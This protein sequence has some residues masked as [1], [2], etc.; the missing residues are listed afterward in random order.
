MFFVVYRVHWLKAKAR[1]DRWDEEFKLVWSEMDWTLRYFQHQGRIWVERTQQAV[2]GGKLGHA[3][4]AARQGSM[5]AK[6]YQQGSRVF[7][8]AKLTYR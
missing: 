6:F 2:Q 8:E 1:A 7:E 5:W 4:Y 3:A